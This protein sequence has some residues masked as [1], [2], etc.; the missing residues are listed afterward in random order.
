[1]PALQDKIETEMP[2][3]QP[4]AKKVDG[5]SDEVLLAIQNLADTA[6]GGSNG[7]KLM[8]VK[9]RN[10]KVMKVMKVK[11]K[12]GT[13]KGKKGTGKSGASKTG[14]GKSKPGGSKRKFNIPFPGQP[15]KGVPP[16]EF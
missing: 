12:K 4:T 6:G 3:E 5:Q 16:I 11:G 8:K 1:M 14:D 10:G 7:T 2:G 15:K 13:G 9:R